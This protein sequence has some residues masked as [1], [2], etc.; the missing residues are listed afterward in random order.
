MNFKLRLLALLLAMMMVL[1]SCEFSLEMISQYLPEGWFA[2]EPQQTEPTPTQPTPSDPVCTEHIDADGDEKCDVCGADV[3]APQPPVC[4]E[5]KDEDGDEKCDVCG[6]DVPKPEC[7]EHVDSDGD[8]KCDVC[9]ADVPKP[10]CSHADANVDYTCDKCGEPCEPTVSEIIAAWDKKDHSMTK[11]EVLALYTLT[12]DEFQAAMDVLDLMVE[13]S[14]TASSAD[15]IDV[16]YDQFETAFYHIAEQMTIASIV[17]YCNMTDEVASERHLSTQEKF[18]DLQD[19]YMQSCR[20]MYL[21]SPFASELFEGWSDEEIREMLEYDPEIV[22]IKKE[23]EELQV[24]FDNLPDDYYFADASVEIYKQIIIKNNQLAKLNGYDNYYEYA[25]KNVYGR[26]YDSEDLALFRQFLVEYVV[27]NYSNVYDDF[28][29]Y[30][31][32]STTRQ[33]TFIEFVNKAFDKTKKNYLLEYLYSL[34]G[35]MGESMLHVFEN[36]NCVF[37]NNSNSHPTAFQTYL[38]ESD[39]P[40]CLFGKNGQSANTIV[41]EIGHYYEAI[42]NGDISSYDLLETHSQGNEFLFINFCKDEMNSSVYSCVRAY[43]LV[44]ACYVMIIATLVDEFEQRVYALDDETI[45]AMTS[46]DFDAIMTDVCEPYGGLDWVSSNI[47]DPLNYWR[48]VAISNPVYYISYAVSAVAAVEIFALAEEDTAAAFKAYTTLVEGVT[49]EDGFLGALKIAE[50][51][52]PFEE[53][54]FKSIAV[55]LSK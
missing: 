45:A 4:E 21:E 15:E 35:T 5:H 37:S 12:D 23:I 40:F 49:E 8:E 50:L 19:K 52:T 47:S 33:T 39:K 9:G 51:Y 31:N 41:H 10:E 42:A 38:Y 25:S 14:K 29:E 20:T 26:D 43:N 2:T 46:A 27:P 16:Y 11:A 34:E 13:T 30:R 44:N 17:Y 3:P 1:S 18:Y 24:Q 22:A 53:D 6:A 32:L 28:M 36:K 48:Q 54:A 7:T 55:T